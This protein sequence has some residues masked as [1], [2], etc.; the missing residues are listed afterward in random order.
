[1]GLFI[2]HWVAGYIN[3]KIGGALAFIPT[4]LRYPVSAI[5]GIGPLWFIQLLFL[6][7][8]LLVLIRKIDREDKL[9]NLCGKANIA[10]IL[11]L[12]LPIWGAAQVLNMPLLTMYRFGIY[13]LAFLLGYF[14]FSH[15]SVQDAVEKIHIPVLILA[16]VFAA[17]FCIYYFGKNYTTQVTCLPITGNCL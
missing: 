14:V 8:L 13:G 16:A 3:I 6:F 2:Y 4:L 17:C 10:V 1:M 11:L 9:W 7:S 15:E 12:A 5:S